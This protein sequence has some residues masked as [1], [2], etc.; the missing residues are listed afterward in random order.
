MSSIVES[1]YFIPHL[2]LFRPTL[3]ISKT[4]KKRGQTIYF[5]QK[6]PLEVKKKTGQCD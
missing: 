6:R 2:I 3:C 1:E 5:P 4:A